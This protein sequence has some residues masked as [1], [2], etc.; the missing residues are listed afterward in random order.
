MSSSRT[1]NP[2]LRKRLEPANSLA[3]LFDDYEESST[4]LR[5][6]NPFVRERK[7][8]LSLH[9][10]TAGVQSLM[11][12][13]QPN[14]LM[15]GYTR[16]MMGF[17]LFHPQPGHIGMIGLGG[18]SL[19]KYCYWYLPESRISVAEISTEVIALRDRF[20]IPK[21]DTR[22]RV[23]CEDGAEFVR[24]QREEF[25]VLVVDG[26]DSA[27]QPPELC[28]Q[29]FYDNCCNALVDD[30]ILVVNICDSKDS[31][32][33]RR[34][35]R[36]FEGRVLVVDGEDTSNT[37]AFAAKGNKWF[38]PSDRAGLLSV[39]EKLTSFRLYSG[40]A[41]QT[42]EDSRTADGQPVR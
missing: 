42:S 25:D 38:D 6:S 21:D 37:I 5:T 17:L 4:A 35:K 28:T 9:F 24:R 29:A 19:Q 27:G 36:S 22:F 2:N 8:K 34:M 39:A 31:I 33:V 13:E 10:D 16:S 3:N 41:T 26:F 18:G 20:S 11:D 32:L 40:S 1:G 12:M 30:G 23:F 7:G 15:L 14:R